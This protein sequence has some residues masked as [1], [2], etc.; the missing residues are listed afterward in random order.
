MNIKKKLTLALL[1]ASS[2]PLIIFASIN[3][4]FAQ[5]TAIE[6]AMS[7]NLKRTE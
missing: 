1:L 4:Y 6:N 3:F 2:V 7:E 5:R